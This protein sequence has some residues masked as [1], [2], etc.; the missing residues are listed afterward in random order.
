MVD[1]ST[2]DNPEVEPHEVSIALVLRAVLKVNTPVVVGYEGEIVSGAALNFIFAAGVVSVDFRLPK[3]RVEVVIP[4]PQAIAPVKEAEKVTEPG[5]VA[6]KKS[7]HTFTLVPET[8]ACAF[9]VKE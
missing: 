1:R 3:L 7:E 8:V 6:K 4:V 2:P 5:G 9:K